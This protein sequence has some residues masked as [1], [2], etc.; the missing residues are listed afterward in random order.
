LLSVSNM[1][2]DL[3]RPTFI[4]R[5]N[6]SVV[7]VKGSDASSFL[8][9]LC[10][11]HIDDLED[12]DI[13]LSSFLDQKGRLVAVCYITRID[14]KHFRLLTPYPTSTCVRDWLDQFLFAEDVEMIDLSDRHSLLFFLG[15]REGQI[16][17]PDFHFQAGPVP[18]T[19]TL[20]QRDHVKK[21]TYRELTENEFESLRV[22]GCV[23]FSAHEVNSNF[24]PLQ[25]GLMR[26]IHW[27]KGCYIGQEVVSRLES[28]E[29]AGQTLFAGTIDP[30]LLATVQLGETIRTDEGPI[31]ILTSVAPTPISGEANVLFVLKR[32]Q[33]ITH[34]HTV[35]S[36]V[37]IDII[38]QHE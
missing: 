8:H 24:N 31:G 9:R 6:L 16:A 36:K 32:P 19:M 12:G 22:A 33:T 2:I 3:L 1:K 37:R 38:K 27:A 23:P 26:T 30:K 20:L 34:A 7:D 4:V 11:N 21:P 10:T 35:L 28:K 29:K 14:A 15:S 25:L 18:S 5:E 17:G 13:N